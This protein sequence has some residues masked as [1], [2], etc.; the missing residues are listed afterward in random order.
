MVGAPKALFRLQRVDHGAGDIFDISWLQ[1]LVAPVYEGDDGELFGQACQIIHQ[2]V[3][4]PHQLPRLEDRGLWIYLPDNFL[5]LKLRSM[6]TCCSLT[7]Q[8][9]V[10]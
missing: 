10:Q 1:L 3:L 9:S 8:T 6:K 7:V 4:D 2:I 5:A